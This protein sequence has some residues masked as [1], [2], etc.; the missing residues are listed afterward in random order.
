M[1]NTNIKNGQTCLEQQGMECRNDQIVRNT[2]G[3]D[4]EYSEIHPNAISDGDD[5][6]K[7]TGGNTSTAWV[8]DCSK[9]KN[10][11]DY[12][13]FTTN[14]GGCYSDINGRDGIGGRLKAQVSSLYNENFQYGASLVD[15][16]ANEND[17]QVIIN[18][19]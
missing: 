2:Y 4:N 17:G 6:G 5:K 11:F 8:S 16:A 3:K 9:P 14:Q 18:Y 12:S 1:A 19:N 7:G 10:Y 15:T 13:N